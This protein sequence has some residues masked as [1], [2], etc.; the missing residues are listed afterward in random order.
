MPLALVPLTSVG[1]DLAPESLL[2]LLSRLERTGAGRQE[3]LEACTSLGQHQS[4]PATVT[5]QLGLSHTA[6]QK[7]LFTVSW[8]PSY[9]ITNPL[10]FIFTFFFY[11]EFMHMFKKELSY[12]RTKNDKAS[13]MLNCS[14]PQVLQ[15]RDILFLVVLL[16]T[17]TYLKI[18]FLFC[19]F[20]IYHF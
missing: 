19:N 17:P 11:F 20:L 12:G 15:S 6:I 9:L 5:T 16:I 4:C 8:D 18:I 3:Q 1:Q 10:T 2:L 13:P 14:L 7:L